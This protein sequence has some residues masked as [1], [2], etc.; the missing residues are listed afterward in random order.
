MFCCWNGPSELTKDYHP[1]IAVVE[2]GLNHFN[3][4]LVAHLDGT[5]I[6]DKAVNPGFVLQN[7]GQTP[8][9]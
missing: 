9:N 5:K 7:G 6:Q 3:D 4:T 1:D 2:M 8:S